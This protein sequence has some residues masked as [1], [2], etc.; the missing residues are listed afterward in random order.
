MR[1]YWGPWGRELFWSD[2]DIP[3]RSP[4]GCI[5]RVF[6]ADR[7]EEKGRTQQPIRSPPQPCGRSWW[8]RPAV[9]LWTYSE[10]EAK[11]A[12]WGVT[13]TEEPWATSGLAWTTTGQACHSLRRDKGKPRAVRSERTDKGG[14]LQSLLQSQKEATGTWKERRADP[15]ACVAPSG[16]QYE[17]QRGERRPE[18]NHSSMYDPLQALLPT[19]P[20]PQPWLAAHG[21]ISQVGKLRELSFT[22]STSLLEAGKGQD[23]V[24]RGGR[25]LTPTIQSGTRGLNPVSPPTRKSAGS[26]EVIRTLGFSELRLGLKSRFQG[27]LLWEPGALPSFT[28]SLI[29]I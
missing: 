1:N 15:E 13:E 17:S 7:A 16:K 29:R 14:G 3:T 6:S 28:H 8:L 12:Y 25:Q 4:W 23:E 27:Y 9:W 20:G 21:P 11:R 22:V 24:W 10:G 26:R 18:G 5:R 19:E 2:F